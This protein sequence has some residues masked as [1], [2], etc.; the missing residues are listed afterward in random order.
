M[1][2]EQHD[3]LVQRSLA[4]LCDY[5]VDLPQ[6]AAPADSPPSEHAAA[7]AVSPVATLSPDSSLLLRRVAELP[8][9]LLDESAAA[10]GWDRMCHGDARKELQMRGL[11]THECMGNRRKLMALTD[12]G[13]KLATDCGWCLLREKGGVRHGFIV[14]RFRRRCDEAFDG[15]QFFTT[16]ASATIAS[17]RPVQ[18]DMLVVLKDG[19]RLAMQASVENSVPAEVSA[20]R[21]LLAAPDLQWVV[22]IAFQREKREAVRKALKAADLLSPK[23]VLLEVEQLLDGDFDLRAALGIAHEGDR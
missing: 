3:A 7:V 6:A 5:V 12:A 16:G 4:V 15:A 19:S 22:F 23:L 20:L 8:P 18:P 13:R 21:A 2:R 11:L 14:G 10:L 1:N 9:E 17:P